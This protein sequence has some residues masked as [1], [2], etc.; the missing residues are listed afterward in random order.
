MKTKTTSREVCYA[1]TSLVACDAGPR[2]LLE[3]VRNHWHIEPRAHHICNISVDEDRRRAHGR[4]RPYNPARLSNAAISI[5]RY[6]EQFA[7]V[8][9]AHRHDT[10]GPRTHS[11]RSSNRSPNGASQRPPPRPCTARRATPQRC[12]TGAQPP[13]NHFEDPENPAPA[14]PAACQHRDSAPGSACADAKIT[15]R[16]NKGLSLD[17]LLWIDT[18]CFPVETSRHF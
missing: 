5:L 12:L 3:P 17:G 18:S 14:P 1:L 15:Q 6:Q 4:Y 2:K 16:P 11:T 8:P 10:P 7:F 13:P 9:P